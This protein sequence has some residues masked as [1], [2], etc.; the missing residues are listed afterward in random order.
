MPWSP[1]AGPEFEE[2]LLTLALDPEMPPYIQGRALE[3]LRRVGN[4]PD[5]VQALDPGAAGVGDAQRGF[6]HR[7]GDRPTGSGAVAAPGDPLSF[8][9]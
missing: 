6:P 8:R 1:G 5:T 7:D 3:A 9:P 2:T 4:D